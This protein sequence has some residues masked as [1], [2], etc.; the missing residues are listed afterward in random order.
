[1]TALP[2]LPRWA[3]VFRPS[4][5]SGV[6]NQ[7]TDRVT[8]RYLVVTQFGHRR[9]HS[10]PKDTRRS[11]LYKTILVRGGCSGRPW[12]GQAAFR[13]LQDRTSSLPAIFLTCSGDFI[14]QSAPEDASLSIPRERLTPDF[15]DP[16]EYSRGNWH[17]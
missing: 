12:F 10:V 15:G 16:R 7:V 2:P 17:E 1:M 4:G 11:G 8:A 3:T 5:T 14:V 6:S 13:S 9:A